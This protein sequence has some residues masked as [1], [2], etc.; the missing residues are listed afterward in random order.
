MNE[1]ERDTVAYH[2]SG[3]R[4]GGRACSRTP[5]RW[6]RSASSLGHA[7][8]SATRC[9]CPREDRYILTQEELTDRRRRHAGR[10]GGGDHRAR[11]H[12]H[13][14]QRRHPE[15]H[16][17][18]PPDGHRVRHER[19]AGVGALRGAAAAVPGR[20]DAGQQ[21]AQPAHPGD[22]RRRG[23]E[24][25][26]PSST[27]EP[28]RCSASTEGRWRPWP[29]SCC[30]TRRWTGRQYRTRLRP[31]RPLTGSPR[32]EEPARTQSLLAGSPRRGRRR[33]GY[34]LTKAA[35]PP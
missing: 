18:G 5:T 13:R 28:R 2:E 19:Q 35:M 30:S 11:H 29:R 15:G 33:R 26:S 23:A 24:D 21:P 31:T 17:T 16:G 4:P 20:R 25:S 12:Q 32:A 34:S 22:D 8:P 9:R 3:P 10:A 14:R 1:Q 27:R 6:P 7:G